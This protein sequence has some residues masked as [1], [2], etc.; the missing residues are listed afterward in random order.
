MN[1]LNGY[2]APKKT[3]DSWKET[4][5]QAEF[6][7][8]N[9][10]I[11]G[12]IQFQKSTLPINYLT[13]L[14]KD[15]GTIHITSGHNTRHQEPPI[16]LDT[17]VSS[18]S[19]NL[20]MTGEVYVNLHVLMHMV[21][22]V[23]PLP[24]QLRQLTGN[25]TGH[26][27]G[28]VP[29]A[30]SPSGFSNLA[31]S[32]SGSLAL[33]LPAAPPYADD[34]T[35]TSKWLWAVKSDEIRFTVQPSSKGSVQ[36]L[37]NHPLVQSL[38]RLTGS[39]AS[40]PFQWQIQEPISGSLFLQKKDASLEIRHGQVEITTIT[41]TE[42]VEGLL[43]LD[44]LAWSTTHGLSG[45]GRLNL[46]TTL[47]HIALPTLPI[48]K[49]VGTAELSMAFSP[50]DLL[51]KLESGSQ[52]RAYSIRYETVG[53][54]TASIVLQS[55]VIGKINITDNSV[56]LRPSDFLVRLPKLT[57]DKQEWTFGEL[58]VKG[59]GI[60]HDRESWKV[61]G[62]LFSKS[63]STVM[64]GKSI[65]SFDLVLGFSAN[66]K[67]LNL[68]FDAQNAHQPLHVKGKAS[69]N[70]PEGKGQ[71]T[72]RLLPIQFNPPII[73]SQLIK[74]WEI[75]DLDV[76]SGTVTANGRFQ[77]DGTPTKDGLP[78]NIIFAHGLIDIKGLDGFVQGVIFEGL[79]TTLELQVRHN[80]GQ[81]HSAVVQIPT[82]Q[83]PLTFTNTSFTLGTE[84]FPL[85]SIPPIHLS[86]GTTSL[87]GGLAYFP[88][89]ILASPFPNQAI[90]VK[91]QDLDLEEIFA[92]EQQEN[93]KGTGRLDGIIPLNIDFPDIEVHEGQVKAQAP[94]GVLHIDLQESLGGSIAQSQPHLD[95]IIQ[96]FKNFHYHTLH[97]G[98]NYQKTGIL[99]L[100]TRLEG[101]NPEYKNGIPF[102]FNLNIEENIPALFKTLSL[103]EDLQEKIEN[104]VSPP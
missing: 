88:K 100:A 89:I 16:R 87:L 22:V 66:P 39:T 76:T 51:F 64:A 30:S 90:A 38:A 29:K 17:M 69:L 46:N 75:Q 43:T 59:I 3:W 77:W 28:S 80:K 18:V 44:N 53:I 5:L 37:K 41:P 71:G 62:M 10:E 104:M 24:S 21:G 84:P 65:P 92:L 61:K 101:K 98:V 6:E 49:V 15:T 54:P 9:K 2:F 40:Q 85:P 4:L 13:L 56:A 23:Y 78:I 32:G 93:I 60:S 94:G 72:F 1:T 99:R 20:D 103:V 45:A 73:L 19:T 25:F 7:I 96:S 70:I 79:T 55:P 58:R 63:I 31:I 26:W 83:S 12:N 95:Q 34:L 14:I 48:R 97:I 91:V 50:E 57:G 67:N 35:L 33:N 27:S 42:Q 47:S 52:L 102:N 86:H 81:F 11:F 68:Q 82:I 36:I 74:P 8:N